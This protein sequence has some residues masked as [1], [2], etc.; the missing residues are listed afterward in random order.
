LQEFVNPQR[1]QYLPASS[2]IITVHGQTVLRIG[3]DAP[4]PLS[5]N[6]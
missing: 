1:A 2:K 6:G 3:Y 4:S 5:L